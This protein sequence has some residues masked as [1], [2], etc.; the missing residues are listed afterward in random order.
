[1]RRLPAAHRVRLAA[2]RWGV[3][4]VLAL[5]VALPAIA[6][7]AAATSATTPHEQAPVAAASCHGQPGHDVLCAQGIPAAAP[8]SVRQA[9]YDD[10]RDV[11][12]PVLAAVALTAGTLMTLRL[13]A[14]F[15]LRTEPPW[16]APRRLVTG[17][18]QLVAI[19]VSRI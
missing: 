9:R 4:T 5:L 6:C 17:Q 15:A 19:G 7:H 1:M 18:D 3:W 8:Q 2:Q 11:L 14:R 13:A 16:W 10:L 12:G